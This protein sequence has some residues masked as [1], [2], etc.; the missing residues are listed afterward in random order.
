MQMK[1]QV[2]KDFVAMDSGYDELQ[3][4]DLEEKGLKRKKV[5]LGIGRSTE[6]DFPRALLIDHNST[7]ILSRLKTDLGELIHSRKRFRSRTS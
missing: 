2:K 1:F 4:I 5:V 3:P 7:L 6:F